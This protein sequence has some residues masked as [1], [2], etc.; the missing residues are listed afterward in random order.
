MRRSKS[1]AEFRSSRVPEGKLSQFSSSRIPPADE[2][3]SSPM[4]NSAKTVPLNGMNDGPLSRPIAVSSP[5]AMTG[6]L[7]RPRMVTS[8]EERTGSLRRDLAGTIS[9]PVART[10]SLGRSRSQVSMNDVMT[11]SLNR[12]REVSREQSMNESITAL[13]QRSRE[14]SMNESGMSDPVTG[15]LGRSRSQV[16]MNDVMTASLN[17]N[18]EV[19]REQS[20]NESMRPTMSESI[21]ALAQRSREASINESMNRPSIK[22]LLNE[23]H[24]ETAKSVTG[25]YDSDTKSS[26]SGYDT[27]TSMKGSLSH[28]DTSKSMMSGSLGRPM[29]VAMAAAFTGPLTGELNGVLNGPLTGSLPRSKSSTAFQENY[30]PTPRVITR[31]VCCSVFYRD[32]AFFQSFL[33]FSFVKLRLPFFI[34]LFN[35]NSE[36]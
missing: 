10:G 27:A 4:L 35:H 23:S 2:R 11:A 16:A 21:T 7:N 15:S 5:S 33:S 29:A 13:A 18:R 32:F 14:A 1:S 28:R 19:P 25:G 24:Y 20:M 6:S 22:G 34:I 31:V 36:Y 3:A 12:N 17:R 30:N 8:T 9:H 26:I